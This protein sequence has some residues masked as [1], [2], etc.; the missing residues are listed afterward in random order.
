MTCQLK[1]EDFHSGQSTLTFAT[2]KSIKQIEWNLTNGP[3]SGSCDSS[4][5]DTQ[6][7]SGSVKRGSCGS[8][9]LEKKNHGSKVVSTHLWNTPLNLYQQAIKG[10]LS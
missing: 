5:L 7:F 3:L 6:V 2:R 8:D 9:F 10:F 1:L 4:L